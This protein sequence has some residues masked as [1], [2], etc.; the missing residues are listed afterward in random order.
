MSKPTKN[1]QNVLWRAWRHTPDREFADPLFET[2]ADEPVGWGVTASLLLLGAL[3]GAAAG[4]LAGLI[5][6][7]GGVENL[8]DWIVAWP[9]LAPFP[10]WGAAA[11]ALGAGLIRAIAGWRLTWLAWLKW[12]LPSVPREKLVGGLGVVLVGF[13]LLFL[14]GLVV[15]LEGDRHAWEYRRWLGWWRGRPHL[16]ALE[17]ALRWAC[18]QRPAVQKKWAEPLRRLKAARSES[19]PLQQW[20]ATL[21]NS[22]WEERFITHHVLVSLGGEAVEPL[23]EQVGRHPLVA[24]GDAALRQTAADLIRDIAQ[25][26]TERLASQARRLLCPRCLARYHAH[27]VRLSWRSRVTYYGCRTCH[28]SREWIDWPGEVVAVLDAGLAAERTAPDGTL[29][30]NWL[31]RKAIFDF[32]RV[33]VVDAP[34]A[35][36]ERFC[37]QVGN[38]RDEWRQ[39]RYRRMPCV[40]RCPLSENTWRILRAQW[41]PVEDAAAS[42][43][44]GS[45]AAQEKE[46]MGSEELAVGE[47]ELTLPGL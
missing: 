15:G 43:G 12:L 35:E 36:V 6:T 9:R 20:I 34:D 17:Q 41:G 8:K 33:E 27:S 30:V 16:F 25:G 26:T 22:D 3:Y 14:V 28:Q 38:D 31:R 10:A 1:W 46:R 37:I 2:V 4:L 44:G 13:L 19:Q 5:A 39:R 11:G 45:L 21:R 23:R 18:E 32:D 42:A 7:N 24:S 40:V 29:R 47:E